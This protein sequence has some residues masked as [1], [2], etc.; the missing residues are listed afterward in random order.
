MFCFREDSEKHRVGR[1]PRGSSGK[2]PNRVAK[3]VPHFHSSRNE[4]STRKN[5]DPR[6][7]SDEIP[8]DGRT[9]IAGR[10][11]RLDTCSVQDELKDV[12]DRLFKWMTD[13]RLPIDR[14]QN[15]ATSLLIKVFASHDSLQE[16]NRRLVETLQERDTR[17][18]RYRTAIATK[19]EKISS[20]EQQI[21]AERVAAQHDMSQLYQQYQSSLQWEQAKHADE[22]ADLNR[23]QS[24]CEKQHKDYVNVLT[25]KHQS[26]ID[27]LTHKHETDIKRREDEYRVEIAHEKEKVKKAEEDMC[28]SVD[29]FQG[30]Q[31]DELGKR[32]YKLTT[33]I[34]GLSRLTSAPDFVQQAEAMGFNV[35]LQSPI[36]LRDH[37]FLFQSILWK[38]VVDGTFLTP[39]RVFGAYG[40]PIYQTWRALFGVQDNA[41]LEWPE[42]DPLAEK[43]RYTTV[44]R[45]RSARNAP[46]APHRQHQEIQ[47]S[48]QDRISS[49]ISTLSHL[50]VFPST[51]N[52]S[53]S[54]ATRLHELIEQASEFATLIAIQRYRVRFFLPSTLG[55]RG[56]L[57]T[58]YVK[59]VYPGSELEAAYANAEFVVSPGLVKEG[60][61]RGG[62]LEEKVPLIKAVVYFNHEG[63]AG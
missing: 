41:L 56:Q 27:T 49:L 16:T 59:G 25:T 11:S 9:S 33:E 2:D 62:K 57:D 4:D 54:L 46:T 29:N 10:K 6:Q 47:A 52:N 18:Q 17:I 43:W 30:L 53:P 15:A 34:E 44:E 32:F 12:E 55:L 36:P 63:S 48:Y 3:F 45:L 20:L 22:V 60:N 13:R 38:I 5:D 61:S 37:T 42:A 39:F 8:Q 40:D 26:L 31:D 28:L 51:N 7:Y 58:K 21:Y 19:D 23:R 1:K 35:R 24:K 50:F 14:S